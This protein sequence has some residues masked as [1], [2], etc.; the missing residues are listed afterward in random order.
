MTPE[1]LSLKKPLIFDIKRGSMDDGEGIRTVLFFKGCP[2]SCSWCHNPESINCEVEYSCEPEKVRTIG[3]SYTIY[4]LLSIIMEDITY[5]E[6]SGGGVTLSGGEPTLFMEYAGELARALRERGI[7]CALQTCGHFDYSDFKKRLL[8]SLD[9]VFYDI[10]LF[11]LAEHIKHTGK[12][13]KRILENLW[14]LSKEKIKLIPRT[15]LIPGITDTDENLQSISRML[16]ELG[17]GNT[18]VKLEYNDAGERKRK[19]LKQG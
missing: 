4:E 10:K 1:D 18:H 16:D 8:P 11:D 7:S 6:V 14:L 12:D 9:C 17:L 15:P 2:L 19:M 13:N 5:Y 3:K